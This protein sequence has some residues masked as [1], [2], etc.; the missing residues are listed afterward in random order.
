VPK[1]RHWDHYET[2][3]SSTHLLLCTGRE[4]ISFSPVLTHFPLQLAHITS[5][6]DART[7][8]LVISALFSPRAH[9]AKLRS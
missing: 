4:Q 5:P 3:G 2:F 6:V 7:L 1:S 8:T 9:Q